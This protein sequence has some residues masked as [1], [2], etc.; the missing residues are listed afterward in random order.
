[1]RYGAVVS[2][3]DELNGHVGL[4]HGGFTSALLDDIF[5]W[6]A[7]TERTEQ[8]LHAETILL[9]A[10]LNVNYRQPMPHNSLYYVYCESERLEKQKKIYLRA[11]VYDAEDAIVA[12]ATS[13]Y[14]VKA[15]PPALTADDDGAPALKA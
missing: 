11:K 14:I 9:T 6:C 7:N 4:L 5:G 3:G 8:G 13:L 1:M 12:D 15:K 2:V 10:N